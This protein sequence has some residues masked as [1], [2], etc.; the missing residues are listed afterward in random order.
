MVVREYSEYRNDSPPRTSRSE[1]TNKT[2]K[3]DI[4]PA[5]FDEILEVHASGEFDTFVRGWFKD[6]TKQVA[7]KPWLGGSLG[8][9]ALGVLASVRIE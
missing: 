8:K 3:T 9:S 6:E 1:T 7:Q 2:E 5:V 4:V